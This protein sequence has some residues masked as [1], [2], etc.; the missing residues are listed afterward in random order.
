MTTVVELFAGL[1]AWTLY[2]HHQHPPTSSPPASRIG[3]KAG[4]AAALTQAF[5][6][7]DTPERVLL[8]EAD[9][10]LANALH[11]LLHHP[12]DLARAVR[13]FGGPSCEPRHVWQRAKDARGEGHLLGAGAWWVWTA[14]ARGGIGGFKGA[15][16]LRPNVDGF[17][18]SLN[19]LQN[20]I[21]LFL[22]RPHVEVVCA[23]AESIDPIQGAVVYLDPPYDGTQGY[24]GFGPSVE[25]VCELAR[26]WRDAGARVGV[27]YNRRLDT[28][29]A[30]LPE[31]HAVDLTTLRRGQSRRSLTRSREEWLTLSSGVTCPEST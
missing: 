6:V 11:F 28:Y 27:S 13:L 29:A 15:H 30:G 31:W 4:Y 25:A 18:P 10:Q 24:G 16:K 21:S 5:G 8:V 19:A 12:R 22:P 1:A 9:P 3:S 14:G 2:L 17:I 20:R 7:T 26:R 23:R